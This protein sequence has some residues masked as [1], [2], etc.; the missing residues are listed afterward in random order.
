MNRKNARFLFGIILV[1]GIF[2]VV[3]GANEWKKT[4]EEE[5]WARNEAVERL[6]E[7]LIEKS[8]F[9]QP[10][11]GEMVGML[12]IPKIEADLPIVEGTHEDDLR[13]GVGH[14][15]GTAYPQENEQI[16]LSGHRDTVFRRM[17]ELQIGDRISMA[18]PYGEF[19]YEIISTKIVAADDLTVITPQKEEVLTISTCYPF[20][21]VGHAPD[22]YIIYAKPVYEVSNQ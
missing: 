15:G 6:K 14:Y 5:S 17:G 13:K 7:P 20:S 11:F 19:D 10:E 2:L 16:F 3:K 9:T 21:Y 1:L 22:R 4:R 18:M 8:S 12:K